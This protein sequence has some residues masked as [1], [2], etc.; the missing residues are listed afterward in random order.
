[1]AASF[2]VGAHV[3]TKKTLPLLIAYV[4]TCYSLQTDALLCYPSSLS[5]Y[6]LTPG[7]AQRG[8]KIIKAG[9]VTVVPVKLNCLA[10]QKSPFFFHLQ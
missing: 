3:T 5:F 8:Q 1:M 10:M 7:G 6:V 2:P 4:C 9:I